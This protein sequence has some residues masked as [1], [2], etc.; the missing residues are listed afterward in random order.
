M[1]RGQEGER[2]GEGGLMG[3]GTAAQQAG[4]LLP[5][6]SVRRDYSFG[7]ERRGERREGGERR[8]AVTQAPSR[9]VLP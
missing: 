6:P 8:A 3:G 7:E 5:R 1:G 2:L 9:K 4:V